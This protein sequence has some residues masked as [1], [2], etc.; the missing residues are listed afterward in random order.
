V[1]SPRPLFLH[2]HDAHVAVVISDHDAM[3]D[4]T[5]TMFSAASDSSGPLII[6]TMV[7]PRPWMYGRRKRARQASI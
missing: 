7:P 2:A 1:S 3:L 5:A 4:Q 6:K